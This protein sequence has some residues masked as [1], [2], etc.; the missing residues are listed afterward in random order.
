MT[1][2]EREENRAIAAAGR[3]RD[4]AIDNQYQPSKAELEADM[5]VPAT[6]DELLQAVINSKPS[7]RG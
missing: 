6:P 1:K 7:K 3:Q 5:S 2:E 4:I